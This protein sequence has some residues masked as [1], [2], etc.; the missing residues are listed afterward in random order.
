MQAEYIQEQFNFRIGLC[1]T[2][3]QYLSAI[4]RW[5]MNI[6]HL[7]VTEGL[8]HPVEDRTD[9]DEV[10]PYTRR[11]LESLAQEYGQGQPVVCQINGCTVP[12]DRFKH[13]RPNPSFPIRANIGCK[14]LFYRSSRAKVGTT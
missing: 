2:L 8:Y 3:K 10:I 7:H 5:Q 9:H 6:Y 13:I 14:S 1:V 4:G 11:T 12:R